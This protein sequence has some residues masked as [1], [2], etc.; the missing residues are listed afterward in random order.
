MI[1][2]IKRL[3]EE[4]TQ[5]DVRT[6]VEIKDGFTNENYLINDAYVIRIPK[7]DHDETINYKLEKEVYQKIEPLKISEKIIYLDENKGTKISKFVH[8][9]RFYFNKPNNEQIRYVAKFL[10]KLHTSSIKVSKNYDALKRLEIYKKYVDSADFLDAKFEKMVINNFKNLDDK[11]SYCLC[12]NDLVKHNLLFK[13]N[14]LIV[15]DWEYAS[16]NT[17]LFDL[18]SFVSE[19]S[20]S[21]EQTI[22]FL[23]QYYGFKFSNL[24]M[25]KVKQ[26]ASFLDILFYYRALHYYKKRGDKLYYDISL[27]KFNHIK[28]T[29]MN[30]KNYYKY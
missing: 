28:E 30:T 20:L 21:Q 23:K 25:K 8:N 17:P 9:T 1:H 2:G 12:H 27:E 26:M 15:I 10:K 18:A 11:S 4:I 5:K 7:K 3:F 13:F 19:N 22:Y 16:M 14:G 29:M 6:Q 24:K